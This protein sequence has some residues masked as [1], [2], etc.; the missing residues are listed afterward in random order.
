MTVT[1]QNFIH[2]EI[3]SKLNLSNAFHHSIQKLLF[4]HL[5]S[6]YVK[7]R[8]YKTIILPVVLRVYGC[9][10]R[11]LTYRESVDLGRLRTGC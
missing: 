3:K 8:M 1:N 6:I 5:L 4:S 10:I 2:V 9:E 7:I 11:S